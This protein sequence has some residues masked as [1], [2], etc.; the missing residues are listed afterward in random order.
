MQGGQGG[1]R[2]G[3]CWAGLHDRAAGLGKV[4]VAWVRRAIKRRGRG[5]HACCALARLAPPYMGW[6]L[7][8]VRLGCRG[9]LVVPRVPHKEASKWGACMCWPWPCTPARRAVPCRA[10]QG[11]DV[12]RVAAQIP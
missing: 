7:A 1:G 2:A 8:A 3:L 12:S 6:N 11:W 10:M 9:L 4:G 5:C